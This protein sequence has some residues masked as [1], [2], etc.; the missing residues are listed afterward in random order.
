MAKLNLCSIFCLC[1]LT[2]SLSVKTERLF[3]IFRWFCVGSVLVLC[4]FCVGSAPLQAAS[5]N[6]SAHRESGSLM[7]RCVVC[8]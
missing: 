7:F 6:G 5:S 1:L 2:S 4:W 3:E 8:D